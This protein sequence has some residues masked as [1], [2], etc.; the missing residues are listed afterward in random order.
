[1]SAY[2]LLADP[3]FLRE[4]V[5]AYYGRVDRIVVSYDR[6][7]V[8]WTGTRLPLDQCLAIIDEIDVD[9]KCTAEPGR[10]AR[11][12]EDPMDNET[13]QRQVALD[14]AS[15]DADWVLQLDTDEVMLSPATFFDAL[16]DAAE[17]GRAGLD[18]PA[19]WIYSRIAPGR[20]LQRST[21]F[22]RKSASYPGPVAVA[23]GTR[24]RYARQA[25][26]DLHRVDLR[27]RSTD[28]WRPADAR[29]DAV[30][31]PEQAIAHFSWVRDP[32]A[33]KRK[34]GWSGHS[35]QLASPRPYREWS[36]RSRHPYL[37]TLLTPLRRKDA[38]WLR[39]A[40]V[41]EPPGG[42]PPRVVLNGEAGRSPAA[43]GTEP[44]GVA[45]A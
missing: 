42:N 20:Y 16:A 14:A 29:V 35:S 43:D 38:G 40:T 7:G 36:W 45:R 12:D 2:I 15:A 13:H 19:H 39:L 33:M 9:H 30:I 32:E 10:F 24:L 17:A 44:P 26:I 31:R 37:T 18:Y 4:S 27:A 23:A 11:L 21:R 5:A 25:D 22:W 6:S 1:M 3:A 41:P 28:P 8:S 34:F